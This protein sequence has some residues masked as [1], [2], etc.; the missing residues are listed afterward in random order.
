DLGGHG[1][2][3][4]AEAAVT[5]GNVVCGLRALEHHRRVDAPDAGDR[6]VQQKGLEDADPTLVDHDAAE[7]R[8]GDRHA[9]DGALVARGRPPSM[10]M[11]APCAKAIKVSFIASDPRPTFETPCHSVPVIA[12]SLTVSAPGL[13]HST[14]RPVSLICTFLRTRAA[15]VA[16][17]TMP[18]GPPRT[19]R[20]RT[21][22]P[23]R[24]SYVISPIASVAA[25]TSRGVSPTM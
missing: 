7:L 11:P 10:K 25:P 19:A 18:F 21:L 15:A 3:A 4:V 22:P 16:R 17:A 1:D 9:L 20:A 14:P 6:V 23:P 8:V 24:A 13:I 12:P 2:H 5:T